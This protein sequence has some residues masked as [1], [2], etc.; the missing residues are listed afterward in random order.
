MMQ[1]ERITVL[2]VDDHQITR[3]GLVLTLQPYEQFSVAG[4][5]A[6]G[7]AAVEQS[8]ALRPA[9]IL[10]DVSMP[11]LDGID[12]MKEI[13]SKLPETRVIVLTAN[14][15]DD[16]IFVALAAGA[17][18]YCLK[19]I[20]AD[21]LSIAIL[22]VH[23]GAAYLD[24]AIARR[25]LQSRVALKPKTADKNSFFLSERE[26]EVL[27]L[28]VDGFSN[29]QI[30]EHLFISIDT[31]KTHMRHILEKL[32]VSDRTQAAVKAVRQGLA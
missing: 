25:V 7:R 4:E 30:A 18:G 5:A 14:D 11:I 10:M 21:Q 6:D 19:D 23:S 3:R 31:V 8:L 16:N 22:A 1:A 12:A 26:L 24:P 28:I 13:K 32:A 9:V 17:D 15:S 27:K 29:Q 2:V 20:A